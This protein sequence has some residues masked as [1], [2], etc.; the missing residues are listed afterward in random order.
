MF[1][2]TN[3]LTAENEQYLESQ[4]AAGRFSSLENAINEL[5]ESERRW[6]ES[7][8]EKVAA[9]ITDL[10]T[11]R[12]TDYDDTSLSGRFDE[13]KQRAVKAISSSP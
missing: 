11:G 1:V 9:G 13:L 8:K 10:D 5:I 4:V 6:S 3:L 2:K 7:A 12:F